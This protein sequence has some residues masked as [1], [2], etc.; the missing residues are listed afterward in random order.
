MVS[1]SRCKRDAVLLRVRFSPRSLNFK[2]KDNAMGLRLERP[3][4]NAR[5]SYGEVWPKGTKIRFLNK[6]GHNFQREEAAK[7]F[8]VDK[9]YTLKASDV[10]SSSSTLEFEEVPGIFNSVMFV[11]AEETVRELAYLKW[12]RAGYPD[13]DGSQF[14][15]EAEKELAW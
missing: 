7:L 11:V 6:N 1:P 14:W 13:G 15:F 4:R 2:R 3:T 8:D 12:E 10:Y 9:S 5:G